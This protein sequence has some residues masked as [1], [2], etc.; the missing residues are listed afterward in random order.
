MQSYFS[1]FYFDTCL[2]LWDPLLFSTNDLGFL[3]LHMI[4][5]AGVENKRDGGWASK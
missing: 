1:I 4:A 5:G 3:T 2:H